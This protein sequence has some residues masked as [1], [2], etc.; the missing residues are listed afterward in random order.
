MGITLVGTVDDILPGGIFEILLENGCKVKA[1]PSGHLKLH[2]VRICRDDTVH[3]EVS[4]YDLTRGRI[5]W[6][7]S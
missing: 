2:K 4:P 1:K 7:V 3:V 5:T 6:R